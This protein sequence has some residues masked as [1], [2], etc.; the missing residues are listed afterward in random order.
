MGIT[1]CIQTKENIIRM[2]KAA[3]PERGIPEMR[4][5]YWYDILLYLTMMTEVTYREYEDDGQYQW[6]KSL[7]EEVWSLLR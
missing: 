3:F 6:S 4:R 1:K 2:A 7:F 5:I